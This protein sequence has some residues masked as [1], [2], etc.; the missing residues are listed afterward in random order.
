MSFSDDAL[1]IPFRFDSYI[2]DEFFYVPLF[3]FMFGVFIF[4]R[5]CFAAAMI[6]CSAFLGSR[7][8]LDG[9]KYDFAYTS[10]PNLASCSLP[11][12]S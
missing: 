1:V 6:V 8:A 9:T 7:R 5:F 11:C 4:R 3:D 10:L 2:R 12:S